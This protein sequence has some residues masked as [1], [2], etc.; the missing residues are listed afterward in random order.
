MAGDT[1]LVALGFAL[2]KA[3]VL[4]LHRA[5]QPGGPAPQFSGTPQD[6]EELF[7]FLGVRPPR[8]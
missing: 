3:Q 6:L 4:A 2:A 1:D 7:K 8:T 5:T